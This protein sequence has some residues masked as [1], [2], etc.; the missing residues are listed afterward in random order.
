M[1]LPA[2]SAVRK[3]I[4]PLL[5][6]ALVV[7]ILCTGLFYSVFAS[8][9]SVAN[10]ASAAVQTVVVA[11]HD[12]PRGAVVGTAD[13][14][15]AQVK[16]DDPPRGLLA[17]PEQAS[18]R[19]LLVA[20]SEGSPILDSMLTS[21]IADG[22]VPSGM[23]ALT[24][25][26][27]DSSS[28]LAVLQPKRHIDLQAWSDRGSEPQIRTILQNVE[29]LAV[30]RDLANN[31]VPAITVL[32]PAAKADAVALADSAAHIRIA[33]RN[34]S[35]S[36]PNGRGKTA[37]AALFGARAEEEPV[38][39]AA[40]VSHRRPDI[41]ELS[42][43]VLGVTDNG[44]RRLS[45]LYGAESGRGLTVRD[46]E[47]HGAWEQAIK[48]T[49]ANKDAVQISE[50]HVGAAYGNTVQ[51][52]NHAW[53]VRVRFRSS[54]GNSVR[55]EPEVIARSGQ[56][57]TVRRTRGSLGTAAQAG[58]AAIV[59]GVCG[60]EEDRASAADNAR[61]SGVKVRDLVIL[62]R[63]QAPALTASLPGKT[64]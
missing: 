23:R 56:A 17:K 61:S 24:I 37:M 27:A 46:L 8:R 12:L 48:E 45:E 29:V 28:V 64:R 54:D 42:V 7:A 41:P 16:T 18:G 47:T 55:I 58:A 4:V 39:H 22:E 49:L 33:L 1:S 20:A 3:N 31:A 11:T 21:A 34:A 32:V 13:I 19:M 43:S 14:R 36:T 2:G 30:P 35:D 40:E 50:A 60:N 52:G 26:P 57:V 25:R 51:F 38:V 63:S 62:V 15:L 44:V 9:L 59:V 6:I 53:R 5:G 10:A